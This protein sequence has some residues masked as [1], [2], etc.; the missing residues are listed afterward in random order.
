MLEPCL[1]HGS[2][3][4]WVQSR[5]T[6]WAWGI[7]Q[8]WLSPTAGRYTPS[9]EKNFGVLETLYIKICKLA[10]YSENKIDQILL[11]KKYI[12]TYIFVINLFR[13][14]CP[15]SFREKVKHLIILLNDK[16][17]KRSRALLD[18][19]EH[20]MNLSVFDFLVMLGSPLCMSVGY[21]IIFK[22]REL[23]LYLKKKLLSIRPIWL[24]L[25]KYID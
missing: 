10:G 21:T 13:L 15:F 25:V 4:T 2:R 11:R 12:E 18:R 23:Y 14:D 17:F 1:Q 16:D 9:F 6:F 20:K 7:Q 8:G 3:Q 19:T 22:I 24:V 5:H